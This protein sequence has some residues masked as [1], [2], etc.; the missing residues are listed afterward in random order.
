[1]AVLP[2]RH[3]QGIGRAMLGHAKSMLAVDGV[4]SPSEDSCSE[5]ARRWV[6]EDATFYL[7]YGF[8][9]LEQFRDLWDAENPALL[10]I[11]IIPKVGVAQ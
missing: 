7:A 3:G 6:R 9:P 5:Q 1:M 11:K 2:E 10:M 8:R 4:F